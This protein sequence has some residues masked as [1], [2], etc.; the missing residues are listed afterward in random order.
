MKRSTSSF[1]RVIVPL[2]LIAIFFAACLRKSSNSNPSQIGSAPYIRSISGCYILGTKANVFLL[3]EQ[4]AETLPPSCRSFITPTMLRQVHIC[5]RAEEVKE[6]LVWS[7]QFLCL[8]MRRCDCLAHCQ[9]GKT[10]RALDFIIAELSNSRVLELSQCAESR[11]VSYRYKEDGS[12][13]ARVHFSVV[14]GV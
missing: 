8:L 2:G 4:K 6:T 12:N 11:M 1:S 14:L 5:N 9:P 10:R 13:T 3:F 7:N